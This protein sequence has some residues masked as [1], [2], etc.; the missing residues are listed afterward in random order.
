[1]RRILLSLAAST[2]AVGAWA[3]ELAPD[4]LVQKITVEVLAAIKTD[5]QLAAVGL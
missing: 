1:M 3:E 2:L 4:Q 5:K